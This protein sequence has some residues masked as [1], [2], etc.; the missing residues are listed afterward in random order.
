MKSDNQSHMALT[1]MQGSLET[2]SNDALRCALLLCGAE[3]QREEQPSTVAQ[4]DEIKSGHCSTSGQVGLGS[5][6]SWSYQ[7]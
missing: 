1:T 5:G 4:Q 7:S 3:A 2:S 6:I